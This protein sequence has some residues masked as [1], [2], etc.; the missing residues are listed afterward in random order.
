LI[1]GHNHIC[2]PDSSYLTINIIKAKTAGNNNFLTVCN[3]DTNVD[4]DNL[5][6]SHDP[7]GTWVDMDNSGVQVQASG[8][9]NV[10]FLNTP[11]GK[12]RYMYRHTSS[13]PCPETSAVITVTVN[14]VTKFTMTK[15]ICSGENIIINGKTYNVNNP[16]GT[17]IITNAF[18]CDSIITID[19][20]Q[21]SVSA[22]VSVEDENCFGFGKFVVESLN[23]ISI[24]ATLTIGGSGTYQI[25]GIPFTVQNLM[26]GNYTYEITDPNGCNVLNK[27][28]VI[29]DFVPFNIDID[30]AQLEDS[31]K[32]TVTTNIA[33]DIIN[34]TPVEGLS[35]DDCLITFAKPINN[36]Q[37]IIEITD[38]AGCKVRD[39]IELQRIVNIDVNIPNIFSPDGDGMNEMF[40]AKCNDCNYIYTMHIFDR[41]GEK[42]FF[43]ENVKFNDNTAGWDGR[44]R[45]K[46]LNPGVYVYLIEIDHGSGDKQILL[47]DLLM[48][49]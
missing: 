44:F 6:G 49:R 22:N 13:A 38:K 31:Y 46:K 33:P 7:G 28:F 48:L 21:K 17:E 37:Y 10:S 26:G 35:C 18:G 8:G 27:S 23:G 34:W 25:T 5:L 19:L 45:E 14:P 39:T 41:W 15:E 2:G 3:D 32:L 1:V 11:K 29:N 4:I 16:K 47:G 12:Y 24:P 9:K 42:V 20:K 36:Q 43:A 30:V 40:F